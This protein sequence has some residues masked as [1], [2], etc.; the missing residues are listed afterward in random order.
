MTYSLT[1]QG[2]HGS[3]SIG[4][5]WVELMFTHLL[6]NNIQACNTQNG[7]SLFSYLYIIYLAIQR[8]NLKSIPS[9]TFLS[10]RLYI[11][12]RFCRQVC[13]FATTGFSLDMFAPSICRSPRVRVFYSQAT[14]GVKTRRR[15]ANVCRLHPSLLHC[16]VTEVPT[17]RSAALR[18]Q[19]YLIQRSVT[20]SWL[21]IFY[22]NYSGVGTLPTGSFLALQ[23]Q[24][25]RRNP[26]FSNIGA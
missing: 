15:Q 16:R 12:E 2:R 18:H 8:F 11:L 23:A 5:K 19:L 21:L 13:K 9:Q 24:C 4:H 6:Y 7:T 20:A 10:L 17:P 22:N 3:T 14:A 1:L 25:M 26:L